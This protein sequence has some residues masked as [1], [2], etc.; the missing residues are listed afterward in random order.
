[1]GF[2]FGGWLLEADLHVHSDTAGCVALGII[3]EAGGVLNVGQIAG[4]KVTFEMTS[5][6]SSY[7][8]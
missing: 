1:M 7:S 3:L 6:S 5:P 4:L 8:P 2:P